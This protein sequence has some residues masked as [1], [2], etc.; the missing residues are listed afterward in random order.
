MMAFMLA[1]C[2]F[3]FS[4][5]ENFSNSIFKSNLMNLGFRILAWYI[6]FLYLSVSGV[7]TSLPE[8]PKYS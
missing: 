7:I 8:L 1:A 6:Y 3:M 2:N 4:Y 5:E